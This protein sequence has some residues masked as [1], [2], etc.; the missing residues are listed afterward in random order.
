MEIRITEGGAWAARAGIKPAARI[1]PQ[2][3]QNPPRSEG[4]RN[5]RIVRSNKLPSSNRA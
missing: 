5:F 3:V 1:N 4:E 2:H